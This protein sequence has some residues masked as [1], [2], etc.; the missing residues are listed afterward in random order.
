M[1]GAHTHRGA[2]RELCEELILTEEQL[3]SYVRSS[4]S[5]WESGNYVRSSHSQREQRIM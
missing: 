4:F 2:A 5:Q 3:G 1:G